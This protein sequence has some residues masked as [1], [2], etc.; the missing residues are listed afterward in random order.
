MKNEDGIRRIKCVPAGELA[1]PARGLS[2]LKMAAVFSGWGRSSV[3]EFAANLV[4]C[5]EVFPRPPSF[6]RSVTLCFGL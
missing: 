6:S 5:R 3:R 2:G 4:F 1:I